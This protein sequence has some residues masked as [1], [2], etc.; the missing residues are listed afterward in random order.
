MPG[1]GTSPG[2][3]DIGG[4]VHKGRVSFFLRSMTAQVL[5]RATQGVYWRLRFADGRFFQ[6]ALTSHSMAFG[7]GSDR[8]LFVGG[9]DGQS[10]GVEWKPGE[11]MYVDLNTILAGPPPAGG[12]TVVFSFEGVYRFPISGPGAVTNPLTAANLPRYFLNDAQNILA[13][14]SR[15]GPSCPSETPSGYQDEL[16]WYVTPTQALLTDGTPVSNVQLQI[17]PQSDFICREIW[18]YSPAATGSGSV[19]FRARRGDG[20]A[21]SNNFIPINSIQ[22]PLFKELRIK[23]GDTFS[24]DGYVVDGSGGSG[25]SITFGL[26]LAGVRRRKIA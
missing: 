23:G 19:V 16:Y 12:Y 20:Y 3:N 11:K 2:T 14:E 25:T 26:Y 8:Q 17:Q 5:P 13:P 6:S 7:F 21:L 22:G 15:F 24:W 4:V 18:P 1:D 10:G 9:M